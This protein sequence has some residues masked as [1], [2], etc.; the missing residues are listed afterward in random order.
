M[1]PTASRTTQGDTRERLLLAALKAFGHRDYDAVST[2]EI[3][4]A[5]DA[6]ISAISYHFGGKQQLYVATAGFIAASFRSQ[7]DG[8]IEAIRGQVDTASVDRCR[9]LLAELIVELVSRMLLGELSADASGFIIREQHNPTAAFDILYEE[10]MQPLQATYALLLG[11]LLDR[12]PEARDVVLMT[13]ALL[14]Q[15][16]AFRSAQTTVLRR[17]R[18]QGFGEDDAAEIGNVIV[19]LT[20]A[21]I[22]QTS[23][24]GK[25]S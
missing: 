5:A 22:D 20:L 1:T 9:E 25:S 12:P 2:R 7:L 8:Q 16:L 15:A 24:P 19:Q 11:R 10:L 4:E 21:A 17:L 23:K 18:Q 13:H 14:G 6:N 3:V